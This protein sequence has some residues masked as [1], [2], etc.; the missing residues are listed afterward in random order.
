MKNGYTETINGTERTWVS[1]NN[2]SGYWIENKLKQIESADKIPLECPLCKIV[3]NGRDDTRSYL[4]F[5]CCEKCYIQFIEGREEK[6]SAG[7][8]PS[9]AQINLFR[10]KR[11]KF[12]SAPLHKNND[13]YIESSKEKEK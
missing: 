10:E 11:K 12:F 5:Q 2:E 1:F 6:W 8:K 4:K 7:E 3:M 9:E 13:A